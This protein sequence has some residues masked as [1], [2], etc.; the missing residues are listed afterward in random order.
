MRAALVALLFCAPA[1]AA[2]IA[3]APYDEIAALTLGRADFDLLPQRP[4]PGHNFDH[5][6]AFAGGRIGER[7]AGQRLEVIE[8][9]PGLPHDRAAG[10]P[11]APLALVPG[12]PGQGLSVSFHRAFGSNALYPLGPRG[13]PLAEARGEGSAAFLFAEDSCAVAL[14][15]HTEY[16]DDLGTNAGHRGEVSFTFYDRDGRVLGRAL[17]SV[18]GGISEHGFQTEDG[19]ARIAGVLVE[20]LDPGGVALDDIRFGCIPRLG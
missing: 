3:P 11:E 13:F 8:Q 6:L 15:L 17:R 2:G 14:R 10:T 19:A 20:N 12:A 5:G 9:A 7:F 4:E 18:P 1:A 16:L